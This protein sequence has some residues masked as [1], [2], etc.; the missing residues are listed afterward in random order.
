MKLLF[1]T[2]FIN[3]LIFFILQILNF[4]LKFF[5]ILIFNIIY[6]SFILLKF[7]FSD[8]SSIVLVKRN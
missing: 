6:I 4:L 8:N 5:N 3:S 7:T 2:L 1:F